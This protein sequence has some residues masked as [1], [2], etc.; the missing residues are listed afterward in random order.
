MWHIHNGAEFQEQPD[1][2]MV[3]AVN[4][5]QKVSSYVLIELLQFTNHATVAPANFLKSQLF[6]RSLIL[7]VLLSFIP[8]PPP[9]TNNMH[10]IKAFPVRRLLQ[11]LHVTLANSELL[12]LTTQTPLTTSKSLE[13]QVP[14]VCISTDF[15][16]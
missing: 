16:R 6:F 7:N 4:A 12:Q 9:T 1:V 3:T 8:L 15:T 10:V 2:E 5:E 11:N 13:L 14:V